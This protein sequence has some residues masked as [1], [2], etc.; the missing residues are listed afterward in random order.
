MSSLQSNKTVYPLL[1]KATAV[2]LIHNTSLTFAQIA[3]F[4]GLHI[5]EV[6][7]IA[8]GEVAGETVGNNP[9]SSKQITYEEIKKGEADP[10]YRLQMN[11]RMKMFI[12]SEE[13][14]SSHKYTPL[15]HRQGRK[16]AILWII[17]KHPE[18]SDN[19]I[20]KLLSS[21]KK[22]IAAIRDKSHWDMANIVPKDPVLLGICSQKDLNAA[23]E[24]A[25]Q[26][27]AKQQQNEN[28]NSSDTE[29]LLSSLQ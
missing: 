22:T 15:K 2:W 5:L 23:K 4:C 27:K 8:D 29:D 17:T 24:K 28:D 10:L 7:G 26:E 3:D 18:I 20:A 13:K 21:T 11:E 12:I 19:A 6:K 1:P 14:K 25:A 16:S 9:I